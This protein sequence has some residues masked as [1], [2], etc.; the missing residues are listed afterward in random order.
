MAFINGKQVL[1]SPHIHEGY[2]RGKQDGAREWQENYQKEGRNNKAGYYIC[3]YAGWGWTNE[4]FNP[5]WDIIPTNASNMFNYSHITANISKLCEEKGVRLDFSKCVGFQNCFVNA[6][7][8]G[9]DTVD[10]RSCN[11]L[12][13]IFYVASAMEEINDL[14]LKEDGSQTFARTSFLNTK[15]LV[16]LKI[17][18]TIGKSVTF[19]HSPL[20]KESITN[21]INALFSTAT[22][23]TLTLNLAAVN[24]AFETSE[25]A[26]DGSTSDEWKALVATKTNWT[27]SLI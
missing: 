20:N 24:K 16:T 17:T 23:Q 26:A 12:S 22:G 7:I 15:K 9:V 3:A 21:V 14:I 13:T 8:T 27:I 5:V 4:T 18:G 11:D 6:S 25:G 10:T 19:E 2:E 1:F